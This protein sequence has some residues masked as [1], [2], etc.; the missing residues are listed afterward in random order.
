[1][2][3]ESA[4]QKR[5]SKGNQRYYPKIPDGGSINYRKYTGA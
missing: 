2:Q 4:L 5:N 1:M 3:S